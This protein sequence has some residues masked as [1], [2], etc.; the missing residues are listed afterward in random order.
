MLIRNKQG[1]IEGLEGALTAQQESLDEAN[2]AL[3]GVRNETEG[4]RQKRCLHFSLD[5]VNMHFMVNAHSF[6][7]KAAPAPAAGSKK[8][9]KK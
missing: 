1:E 8:K 4:V 7:K 5:N 2:A 3:A 9:Q 6:A